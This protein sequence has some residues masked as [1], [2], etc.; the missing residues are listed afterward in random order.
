MLFNL[1]EQTEYIYQQREGALLS[2]ANVARKSSERHSLME[3]AGLEEMIQV[4]P[5][6]VGK[7]DQRWEVTCP[8]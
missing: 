4:P 7:E 1:A 2:K 8:R 6:R 5:L 3:L